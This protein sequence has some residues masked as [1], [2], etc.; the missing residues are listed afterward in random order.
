MSLS[1]PALMEQSND[2]EAVEERI[3]LTV[4]V[5][6]GLRLGGKL[7]EPF[8]VDIIVNCGDSPLY[9]QTGL[10]KFFSTLNQQYRPYYY[11]PNPIPKVEI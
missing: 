9:Q 7:V 2:A 10:F 8:R 6:V 1:D 3:N 4:G 11:S 5:N